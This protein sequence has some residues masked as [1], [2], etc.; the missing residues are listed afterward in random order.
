VTI[1]IEPGD[2]SLTE[3]FY[4]AEPG[5]RWTDGDALLPRHFYDGLYDGFTVEVRATAL[6]CYPVARADQPAGGGRGTGYRL[7]A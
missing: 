4:A 6:G 1:A 3:G 5:H 2:A 7:A